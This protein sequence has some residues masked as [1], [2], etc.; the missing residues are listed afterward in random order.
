MPSQIGTTFGSY[1]TAPRRIVVSLISLE[2][3]EARE[4]SP[5]EVVEVVDVRRHDPAGARVAEDA[6]EGEVLRE[7][8]T[9]AGLERAIG[10]VDG[11]LEGG[12][13]RLED[14]QRCVRR[15]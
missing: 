5:D 15:A 1:A 9:A 13:A 8:G 2:Q 6:L 11:G 4:G 7:G 10:H 14:E 12:E 3:W